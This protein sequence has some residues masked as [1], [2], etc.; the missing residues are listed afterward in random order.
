MMCSDLILV[1]TVP[2]G[3]FIFSLFDYAFPEFLLCLLLSVLLHVP[4]LFRALVLLLSSLNIRKFLFIKLI[5]NMF[6]LPSG[7]LELYVIKAVNSW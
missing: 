6:M 3:L 4:P 7:L 5:H 1:F 2:T